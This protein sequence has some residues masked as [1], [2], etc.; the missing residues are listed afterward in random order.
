MA[1]KYLPRSIPTW[2]RTV[3]GPRTLIAIVSYA[4]E[5]TIAA[6]LKP[7]TLQKCCTIHKETKEEFQL[8]LRKKN[9]YALDV[10]LL[11]HA[12]WKTERIVRWTVCGSE[13]HNTA[14]HPGPAP[15]T[16]EADP[17]SKHSGKENTIPTA[18]ATSRWHLHT[19]A[20]CTSYAEIQHQENL[21]E[22]Q[23]KIQ[24]N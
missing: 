7:Y 12:W 16:K 13:K 2:S 5:L 4:R 3:I 6:L 14:S 8:S 18:D 17:V 10:V 11:S 23:H 22:L 15:R 24:S 19:D 20:C 1:P 9:T 21:H